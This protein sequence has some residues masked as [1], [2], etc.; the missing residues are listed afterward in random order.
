MFTGYSA[1]SNRDFCAV[2]LLSDKC[3]IIANA[4]KCFLIFSFIYL[5]AGCG[6]AP[7]DDNGNSGNQQKTKSTFSINISGTGTGKVVG[8]GQ[9]NC[10][11]NCAV[12]VDRNDSLIELM[13]TP[14]D[15][16]I[17]AGW[18]GDCSGSDSV[19][20]LSA[21]NDRS[22]SAVFELI[23]P[24]DINIAIEISGSGKISGPEMLECDM[25]CNA[26]Y[27][28]A[29]GSVMLLAQ[30]EDGFDFVGWEGACTSSQVGCEISLTEDQSVTAIFRPLTARL[31]SLVLMNTENGMPVPGFNPLQDG[32]VIDLNKVPTRALTIIAEPKSLVGSVRFGLNNESDYR[33]ESVA[34]YALESDQVGG[35]LLPWELGLGQYRV[36]ATPYT[37]AAAAGQA[38]ETLAVN[39]S[40]VEFILSSSA[41]TLSFFSV[42][43]QAPPEKQTITFRNTGNIAGDFTISGIPAW[44]SVQPSNG[45][46]ASGEELS[47]EFSSSQCTDVGNEAASLLVDAGA[48]QALQVL[49]NRNCSSGLARYD[50]KLD[51]FYFNQAVPAMDSNQSLNNQI[52]TIANR[53]GVARAFVTAN[54]NG[55]PVPEVKLFWR[56]A[57]GNTGSINMTAPNNM[58]TS[59]DEGRGNH[60]YNA[61]LQPDFFA[62]GREFY[63]EID[64]DNKVPETDETNNR[65]PSVG[66]NNN[67]NPVSGDQCNT[68]AQCRTLFGNAATDCS[69][70]ASNQSV[71]MCGNSP[72]GNSGNVPNA[73][74][75]GGYLPLKLAQVARHDVT[76]IPINAL[77]RTPTLTEEFIEELY[78]DTRK[79]NPI[80][81]YDLRFRNQAYT[82][83]K[84]RGYDDLPANERP[85]LWSEM[86][87]QIESLRVADGSS[88]YYH[89]LTVSGPVAGSRVAG[90]GYVRGRSAASL[91]RPSTIA[92]EFGHNFS[93]N[94]APCGSVAGADNNY[95]YQNARVS[96]YG[97]DIFD[98]TLKQPNQPDFMSYCP[99][100]WVSDWT[101]RK[102]MNFRGGS[103]LSSGQQQKTQLT[104]TD[105][106]PILLVSGML[107]D[108]KFSFTDIF[109]LEGK[110][111]DSGYSELRL[112]GYDAFG[113]VLF[114]QPFAAK[115]VDHIDGEYHFTITVSLT[116]IQGL[117]Q[118]LQIEANNEILAEYVT[119]N[120]NQLRKTGT[121]KAAS[122]TSTEPGTVVITWDSNAYK[123][124]IVRDLET[125]NI[126]AIDSSGEVEVSSFSD[127]FELRYSSGL[128]SKTEVVEL[129]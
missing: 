65:Y 21:A 17:F 128:S 68:T 112:V 28:S 105:P 48:A 58:R 2:K 101:F 61:V 123:S 19:C 125:N 119:D 115:K 86:L 124:A 111:H 70:S 29:L 53:D 94:H 78:I 13:A 22:V 25:N 113:L 79:L 18:S 109:E 46:I 114:S 4:V 87:R 117:L 51:R 35:Q 74:S 62:Q 92:H 30:P 88:R 82:F 8:T 95:P 14:A 77:N 42:Q 118:K 71:C 49:V 75:N 9:I 96:I 44:L 73:N 106:G 7:D 27:S 72:C 12:E 97:Y 15:N 122:A 99:Q 52:Y 33:V 55:A 36:T 129:Q 23:P 59:L 56:D 116:D 107:K 108:E 26:T 63:I 16:S 24:K 45:S 81:A 93:L 54:E 41:N 5:L 98:R 31:E 126:V 34:P 103:V 40:L 37:E 120:S 102:V 60:T 100:P 83:R 50:F 84:P 91:L 20:A 80:S 38:G 10:E 121:I 47:V 39:F 67:S 89:G 69:D 32:A 66:G 110:V 1:V 76:F 64:P 90:I 43:D 57:Q 3:T 6:G 11:T 85:S 127:K 104:N